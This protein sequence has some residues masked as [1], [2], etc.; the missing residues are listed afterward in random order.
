MVAEEAEG[1]VVECHLL[2]NQHTE[3]F[4]VVDMVDH[5]IVVVVTAAATAAT[6]VVVIIDADAAVD[7]TFIVGT[8]SILAL[9][10]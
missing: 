2:E 8:G 10:L 9:V 5:S 3:G 6:A 1:Y 4:V 7:I